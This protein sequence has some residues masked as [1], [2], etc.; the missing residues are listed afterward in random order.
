M[1]VRLPCASA[2]AC[3]PSGRSAYR[4]VIMSAPVGMPPAAA[5]FPPL[6]T[7]GDEIITDDHIVALEPA[8]LA[9]GP[10][11]PGATP[12]RPTVR[13]LRRRAGTAG[14]A[15][16]SAG[17]QRGY[18]RVVAAIA[19]LVGRVITLTGP[20]SAPA[21]LP[22]APPEPSAAPAPGGAPV[23]ASAPVAADAPAAA[24]TPV[25][26]GT[27]GAGPGAASRRGLSGEPR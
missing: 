9:R 10:A 8:L 5:C 11:S 12:R 25:E 20:E 14:P 7:E 24:G 19:R 17:P 26:A 21:G 27:A 23:A 16:A 18:A 6:N 1:T 2:R 13:L 15:S 22:T 3:K 4:I